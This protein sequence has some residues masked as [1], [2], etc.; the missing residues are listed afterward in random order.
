MI[1]EIPAEWDGEEV[2]VQE[3]LEQA[4]RINSTL[5]YFCEL[6]YRLQKIRG[7]RG[8]GRQSL[9]PGMTE[10]LILIVVTPL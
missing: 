2:K 5:Q 10:G 1:C 6:S 7:G 4:A 8:G 3:G 9:M